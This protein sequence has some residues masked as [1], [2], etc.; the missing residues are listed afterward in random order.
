MPALE[1]QPA[2]TASHPTPAPPRVLLIADDL[3][4]ACD[5]AAAFLGESTVR[6]WLGAIGD[7][8]TLDAVQAFNTDSRNMPPEA[9]ARAVADCAA[10]HPTGALLF[11]KIDS[12]GRGPIA[13]ELL[14]A[15]QAF[16]TDLILFTPSFPT[17][18]R[19]V[20]DG[21]L[22]VYPAS[23][24]GTRLPLR[25]LFP[26]VERSS[27]AVV[28]QPGALADAA[29]SGK[30][31]AIC[32]AETDDDLAAL[33]TAAE[34]LPQ[35]ILYAGSA[36][37]AHALAETRRSTQTKPY[38]IPPAANTLLIVGTQHPVTQLQLAHLKQHQPSA[39]PHIIRAET[40]DSAG[41]LARFDESNPDTLIL[42]GGDTALLTLRTLG[43]RSIAL[44]GEIAPGVPWGIIDGGLAH[45]RIVITKS[46]GFGASDALTHILTTLSGNA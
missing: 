2:D 1:T 4:G 17:L 37:L 38:T 34:A 46:G 23:G 10:Q 20:S 13:A 44:R 11:K 25:T 5:A 42:T 35:R 9:A 24:L 21:I 6:V 18:G 12:A 30:R 26:L 36:G 19:I 40:A 29:A 28:T 43:A 14:A 22:H 27:I 8:D 41:I 16:G 39:I 45:N 7:N 3:T 31:I 32:D 15:Q 33:V